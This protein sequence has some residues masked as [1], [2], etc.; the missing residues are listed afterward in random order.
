[1]NTA[2]FASMAIRTLFDGDGK[3]AAA[4]GLKPLKSLSTKTYREANLAA[5]LESYPHLKTLLDIFPKKPYVALLIPSHRSIHPATTKALEDMI[6]ASWGQVSYVKGR[7]SQHA[8]VHVARNNL[9]AYLYKE[10][11]PF[12]YVLFVDDDMVPAPDALARM[13]EQRVD[14]IGA[15]CTTRELPLNLNISNVDPVTGIPLPR[16]LSVTAERREVVT[17]GSIGAAFLLVS[18]K[19]LDAIAEYTITHE[20]Y[21]RHFGMSAEVA[22]RQEQF[23][24]RRF[25]ETGYTSW[26]EFFR[27][28]AIELGEDFSFCFKARECGFEIY[29]DSRFNVGHIGVNNRMYTIEDYWKQEGIR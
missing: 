17:V 4:L 27:P 13:L 14:V 16:S 8:L 12:D 23:A 26:F 18:R 15:V 7:S 20:F 21:K 19:A 2:E 25:L 29:A 3:K 9:I 22:V 28:N 5:T 24:R 11:I 10:D 6:A 1:M